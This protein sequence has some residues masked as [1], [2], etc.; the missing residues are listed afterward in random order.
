MQLRVHLSNTVRL[1]HT[2]NLWSANAMRST[3][4]GLDMGDYRKL[5]KEIAD[6]VGVD[7][8]LFSPILQRVESDSEANGGVSFFQSLEAARRIAH[9][10]KF[11]GEW[12]ELILKAFLK[13][14]AR[15]LK[16]PYRSLTHLLPKYT[17]TDSTAVAVVVDIPI[18]LIHNQQHLGSSSEVYTLKKVDAKYIVDVLRIE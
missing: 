12:R 13:K 16:V 8:T 2:T 10:A 11:G 6:I 1:Y 4:L 17:G 3:G 9:Y 14:A 7:V 18:S 5:A 15:Q